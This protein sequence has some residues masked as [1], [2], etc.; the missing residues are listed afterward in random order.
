MQQERHCLNI[1]P[2]CRI[3]VKSCRC[4]RSLRELRHQSTVIAQ[5]A[6]W[7]LREASPRTS[8]KEHAHLLSL[9]YLHHRCPS[10]RPAEG[11]GVV[12]RSRIHKMHK[13]HSI[14]RGIKATA[15]CNCLPR[16]ACWWGALTMMSVS[17]KTAPGCAAG[18]GRGIHMHKKNGG[19]P[20]SGLD[21]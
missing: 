4:T 14:K 12:H 10:W 21:C 16:Q 18:P 15:S 8:G 17:S 19:G 13:M 1:M 20:S 6:C 9:H 7:Y 2:S 3:H 5:W 11:T